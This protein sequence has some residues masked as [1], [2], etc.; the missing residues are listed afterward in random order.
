MQKQTHSAGAPLGISAHE[1]LCRQILIE[2][3]TW[4][5]KLPAEKKASREKSKEALRLG[6]TVPGGWERGGHT[7]LKVLAS[8]LTG[9]SK[10]ADGRGHTLSAIYRWLKNQGG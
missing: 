8:S 3:D 5:V 4:S 7:G 9:G 10:G 2:G 6:T 1:V